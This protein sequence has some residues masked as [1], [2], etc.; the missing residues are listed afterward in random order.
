MK[1]GWR[2]KVALGLTLLFLGVF[3]IYP[4]VY[5][6][7]GSVWVD[8]GFTLIF[9]KLFAESPLMWKCLF[10]SLMLAVLSTVVCAVISLPLAHVFVRYDFPFKPFWQ[11][12]LMAPMILPPFVGAIGVQQLL[13][14]FGALNHALGLVGPGVANPSPVDWLGSG[15]L[16]GIVVMQSLHLF[17]I[18][19]LNISASL[20]NINPAVREAARCLGASPGRVFRTITLPL[21][22]PGFFAGAV[23]VFVWA[24]TDLGTPLV[25]G[26]YEVVGVQIWD[27]VTETGFNPFGYTLVI[28]VLLVTLVAFLWSRRLVA[29]QDFVTQGK[30]GGRDEMHRLRGW[31]LVP[32]MCLIVGVCFLA[33]LPHVSVILQSLSGKWFMS[34]LPQQWTLEHYGEVFT[35]PQ[36]L[37]GLK[38]S[39]L[40]SASSALIDVI[41]GVTI[42]YWLARKEFIGKSIL[43]ALT[44][45]PL[46]LPGVVLAFGYV[47]A[48]NVPTVFHALGRDWDLQ[49]LKSF[50]NPRDNPTLLLVISYSVR[51]LP[52]IVRAAYAGLQQMSVSLEE[53]SRNLGAGQ[54]TTMRRIVLPLLRGNIIAGAVLTF[55][56]A[57]LEVSDSLILA[58]KENY[59]P[60]TK[61]IW[62]LMGRIEP[63]A[64]SVACALGVLGMLLLFAAFYLANRILGRR[65]GSLFG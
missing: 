35:L 12:L 32:A 33:L 6:L 7:R 1:N 29:K 51:R 5:I 18:L 40:F 13:G 4:I 14:R 38:N 11:A 39:F 56:F 31:G 45:L 3:L 2:F 30:A 16:F 34:A 27:K 20:A 25:F 23:I 21:L 63:G 59:Y 61:T 10:N 58:M 24:F 57:F 62:A 50:V 48:F 37:T 47:V 28:V 19:F 52:Y 17:P 22:M 42:A 46:A 36:T 53:A 41:L 44:I 9:F 15:G 8:G 64:A 26:F 55:A 49:W 60:V 54:V 65:M 43:D